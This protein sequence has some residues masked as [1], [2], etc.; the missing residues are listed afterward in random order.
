[1]TIVA[2]IHLAL[3]MLLPFAATA[4]EPSRYEGALESAL[5][6]AKSDAYSPVALQ[7][8]AEPARAR[9][10]QWL[11]PGVLAF[12]GQVFWAGKVTDVAIPPRSNESDQR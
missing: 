10:S 3:L 9:V 1:M 2:R 7:A 11:G 6:L 8:V 4:Q 5:T 12:E